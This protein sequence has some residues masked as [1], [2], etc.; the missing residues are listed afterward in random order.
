MRHRSVVDGDVG[1]THLCVGEVV[2]DGHFMSFSGADPA[3]ACV[4]A[5]ETI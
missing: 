2:S 1:G 5:A 4:S 3:P